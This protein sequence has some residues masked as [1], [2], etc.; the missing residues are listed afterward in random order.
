[1][2]PVR[3][4]FDPHLQA[5]ISVCGVVAVLV[6][7]EVRAAVPLAWALLAGGVNV[8][9]LTLRTPAALEALVAIRAEVPEM[10]AGIG[11][12]LTPAQVIQ[13]AQAGASFGVAPGTNRA[14]LEMARDKTLPFAPGVCTP[15]D[16]ETALEY[17]CR[18]LKYFPAETAGGLPHL[19]AMAAP[20]EH[21]GLRYLP[22]GG[23]NV[24]TM[25]DYLATPLV[26]AVGGSWLAKRELIQAAAWTEITANAREARAAI[27][28]LRAG[29][30]SSS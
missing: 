16:I 30:H 29:A 10:I 25:I 6:I 1:M 11:T 26:P 2:N 3:P 17:Q 12:V 14:V 20:Y 4:A 24:A 15:S 23:L 18:L 5:Q 21:L 13:A 27:D 22:L 9:E 19:A 7:D 28:R 8:M